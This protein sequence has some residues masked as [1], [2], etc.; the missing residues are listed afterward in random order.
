MGLPLGAAVP[1]PDSIA[2]RAAVL[3]GANR[4]ARP[5]EAILLGPE[6]ADESEME[7]AALAFHDG[8]TTIDLQASD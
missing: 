1:E 4:F 3:I 8:A 6:S 5:R 2:C 7:T